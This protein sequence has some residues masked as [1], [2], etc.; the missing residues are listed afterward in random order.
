MTVRFVDG[1]GREVM[2]EKKSVV[3]FGV[4]KK[5]MCI[6]TVPWYTM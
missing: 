2:P 5:S 6:C 3:I 1:L 4:V